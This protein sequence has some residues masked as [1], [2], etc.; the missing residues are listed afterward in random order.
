MDDKAG[1]RG[2]RQGQ[3]TIQPQGQKETMRKFKQTILGLFPLLFSLVPLPS[4]A[5]P[6]IEH[7]LTDNG[8]RVY[9]VPASGLPMIDI[10]LTFDAGSARDGDKKGVAHLSNSLLDE[11]AGEYNADQLAEHFEN[12]GAEIGNGSYRDMSIMSLRSLT[13]PQL[14]TPALEVF[15]LMVGKPSFP[16][17]SFERN[18]KQTLIAIQSQ[19]QSPQALTDKA[20]FKAIYGDHPYSAPPLG[21]ESTVTALTL[22]DMH[23]HYQQYYVA[24]NTVVA[25]VGDID[26]ATAKAIA[27]QLTRGLAP[28]NAAP[29]VAPPA[30]IEGEVVNIEHPSSQ[31]HIKIGQTGISR[32]DP[33]LF[34]LYV[35]NHIL[36][37]SGLGSRISDEIR[38]KRGLAYS[39]YSFFSPMRVSGPYLMG[40]QTRN[41]QAGKAIEVMFATLQEFID[42]GVTAKE[43]E[44]AK[45]DITG[46]FPLRTS[47]N[48][49][50]LGFLGNIGFYN[51][52][53]DYLDTY[54]GH[55]NAVTVEQI[56]EAFQRRVHPNKMVTVTVGAPPVEKKTVTGFE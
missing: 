5:A 28:G 1:K 18:K 19:R 32:D 29:R 53:L 17:K 39:A 49:K 52:P 15:A 3:S 36:G 13:D 4:I 14:L 43:L 44:A 27:S 37:G 47:S 42:N 30:A 45:R 34:P 25:M 55:I 38:E 56:K 2:M 50:I 41:D 46:G 23:Q 11:G 20:F 10:Q 12:L 48:S 40:L 26:R 33:D 54:T 22:D 31:T 51:L 24:K 8:A 21:F 6:A 9:F 16:E 35:G 7:W